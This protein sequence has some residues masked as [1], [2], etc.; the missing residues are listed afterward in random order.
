[1]R[2][3]VRDMWSFLALMLGL[4]FGL[5]VIGLIGGAI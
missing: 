1:M 3:D 4:A 5:L 2:E